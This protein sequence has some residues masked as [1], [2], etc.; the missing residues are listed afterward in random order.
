MR[1]LIS[2]GILRRWFAA[3]GGLKCSRLDAEPVSQKLQVA[4]KSALVVESEESAGEPR[5]LLSALP[6]LEVLHELLRSLHREVG[7][8]T[9]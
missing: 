5:D 2:R 7:G 3:H 9:D 6:Q 4:P 8:G 1:V